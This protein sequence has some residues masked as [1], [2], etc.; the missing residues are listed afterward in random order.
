M[1]EREREIDREKKNIINERKK[2]N[3]KKKKMKQTNIIKL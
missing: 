3:N 1:N 2:K